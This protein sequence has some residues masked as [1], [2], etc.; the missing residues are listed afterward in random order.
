MPL[1]TMYVIV[2]V[3]E[4]YEREDKND[5]KIL[6]KTSKMMWHICLNCNH[7]TRLRY[8]WQESLKTLCNNNTTKYL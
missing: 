2:I 5:K 6:K 7:E 4:M 8:L 1:Y 3:E